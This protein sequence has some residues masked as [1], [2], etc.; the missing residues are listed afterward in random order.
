MGIRTD[1]GRLRGVLHTISPILQERRVPV[2]LD[3]EDE[4]LGGRVIRVGN[5]NRIPEFDSVCGILENLQ[6]SGTLERKAR[7]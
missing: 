6:S 5:G 7:R 4:G 2:A 1:Y 3:F